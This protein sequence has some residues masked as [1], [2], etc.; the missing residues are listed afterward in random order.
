MDLRLPGVGERE[1][2][3]VLLN[4]CRVSVWGDE[5]ALTLDSHDGCTTLGM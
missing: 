4:G 3:E 2:W 5:R 1:E